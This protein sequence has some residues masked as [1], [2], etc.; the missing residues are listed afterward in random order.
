[1]RPFKVFPS[2][3]GVY[4]PVGKYNPQVATGFSTLENWKI[5]E[6][7]LSLGAGC[8]PCFPNRFVHP[9]KLET[10]AV[11]TLGFVTVSGRTYY[12]DD[13]TQTAQKVIETV[14]NNVHYIEQGWLNADIPDNTNAVY[15]V[16][17]TPA[18][19][20]KCRVQIHGK[21]GT[22]HRVD[23]NLTTLAYT[24]VSGTPTIVLKKRDNGSVLIAITVN[25]LVGSTNS[26]VAFQ[27]LDDTGA[28]SYAGDV[29]KGI[30]VWGSQMQF[31]TSKLLP[32]TLGK[33]YWAYTTGHALLIPS[34][35]AAVTGPHPD[36]DT[37]YY[38]INADDLRKIV[39]SGEEEVVVN[40]AFLAGTSTSRLSWCAFRDHLLI[41][42]KTE[43]LK[44]LKPTDDTNRAVGV[45]VPTTK[46]TA[47]AGAAGALTGVYKYTVTFVND[48]GHEGNPKMSG[49]VVDS[50][51]VTLAAQKGNLTSI[52]LG[53]TG[54]SSRRI[55]RTIANGGTFLYVTTINDNTT[56]T[57]TGDNAAD[58]SLGTSLQFDNDVPPT[59]IQNIL[60]T[61]NRVYL[62]STDGQTL[63]ASKI[64]PFTSEPNW[65]AYPYKLSNTLPFNTTRDTF[66]AAFELGGFVYC[67]GRKKIFRIQGDI[68]TG[69]VV[70]KALDEGFF[71]RFTWAMVADRLIY[72]N[73]SKK[74]RMWTGD[75]DP[76]DLGADIQEDLNGIFEPS[77]LIEPSL[78]HNEIDNELYMSFAGVPGTSVNKAMVLD[79][80]TGAAKETGLVLT[81][82]VYQPTRRKIIGYNG[83]MFVQDMGYRNLGSKWTTQIAETIP[84]TPVPG[85]ECTFGRI[86]LQVKAVPIVAFVPPT[87]KVEYALD[88]S[89]DWKAKF[90]DLTRDFLTRG[91][92]NT[93]II[94]TV[95]VPVHDRAGSIKIRIS[96]MDNVASLDNGVE[97]YSIGVEVTN[98]AYEQE[99]SKNDL[100]DRSPV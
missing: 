25:M 44:W 20:T 72:L 49:S 35:V 45:T 28:A 43:G 64:D 6:N 68:G 96:S 94:K 89:I 77:G 81:L 57:L 88:E 56:T 55:Y 76:V 10:G 67:A 69:I 74:L 3:K 42:H 80:K 27:L 65:E 15:S 73:G 12:G 13:G 97:I 30:V 82:P 40:A 11:W 21:D 75:G 50:A 38:H 100:V 93:P 91:E 87:L 61:S 32:F 29:A 54:T 86:I 1:M 85:D 99:A 52:P 70:S 59:T 62:V 84:I 14:D 5:R 90:V 46:P 16:Y 22:Y 78:V 66:Q 58:S 63:W 37:V 71:G 48:K 7:S 8:E 41:A 9:L 98:E 39:E 4:R 51:D 34:Q 79:V 60:A 83:V 26:T 53:P 92:G 31:G 24:V 47:A 23:I 95:Y 17:A 18:G 33:T 36:G 2:K 19:R